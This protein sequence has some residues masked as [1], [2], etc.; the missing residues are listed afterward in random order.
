VTQRVQQNLGYT[1]PTLYRLRLENLSKW[2][3]KKD[4]NK[5]LTKQGIL[6]FSLK[7]VPDQNEALLSFKSEE[8]RDEALEKLDNKVFMKLRVE[9]FPA[10]S[11]KHRRAVDDMHK[12][13]AS[14]RD[15]ALSQAAKK[16][17]DRDPVEQL[18]D[19]ITPLWTKTYDEQLMIKTQ[20]MRKAVLDFSS[21]MERYLPK[22]K[23]RLPEPGSQQARCHEQVAWVGKIRQGNRDALLCPMLPIARAPVLEGY[24]NKV[25]FAFGWNTKGEKVAGF[26]LGQ[27]KDG[28]VTVIEANA[29]RNVSTAAAAIGQRL[30]TFLRS[31]T[32][33][34]YDRIHRTGTWRMAM[35]RTQRTG[36]NMV[37]ISI[38]P[39]GVD[40][41]VLETELTSLRAIFDEAKGTPFEVTT[42]LLHEN[43]LAFNGIAEVPDT[44]LR[45]LYGPGA[46]HETLLGLKFRI[47]PLAFFQVTT[48]GAEVLYGLIRDWCNLDEVAN[49]RSSRPASSSNTLTYK[50]KAKPA[51]EDNPIVNEPEEITID[52]GPPGTVLLDLCCG[53]GTIGL[54]MAAAPH[55]KKVVGVDI[56]Q[57]AIADALY[58]VSLNVDTLGEE[59]VA[60]MSYYAKPVEEIMMQVIHEHCGPADDVVVVLDPP[61][62]GVHYNVIR[63][64][65]ACKRIDRVIYAACSAEQSLGNWIDLCRPTSSKFPNE[66]FRPVRCQP[67]DLFPHTKKCELV[68]EFRRAEA[69]KATEP[70][71]ASEV[72]DPV[73]E[74]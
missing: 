65:R 39:E 44:I 29:A 36:E 28:V 66:P 11:E 26:L 7:K 24:R 14:Q 45:T 43:A 51:T 21:K 60:K 22:R 12:S 38:N 10:A 64:I 73:D 18:A 4:M 30:T 1:A 70:A 54:T 25:E 57:A 37:I 59:G 32:L 13:G 31:S 72:V 68:L 63:H 20:C 27:Y 35:V 6:D 53:T 33:D 17:D 8:E 16:N 58:N 19:T 40:R 52:Y 69:P 48:E 67:V 62:V 71:E 41:A 47:S 23:E 49:D 9:A 55:V 3:S 74:S 2:A 56:I 5:W 42:M 34:I 50:P 61:R 46:V 15:V